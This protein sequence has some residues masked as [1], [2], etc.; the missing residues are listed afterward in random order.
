MSTSSYL[1]QLRPSNSDT[2]GEKHWQEVNG[3][4]LVFCFC[5]YYRVV[6]LPPTEFN[7]PRVCMSCD[8]S[9]SAYLQRVGEVD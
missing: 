2:L 4:S 9:S 3:V 6:A 1:Q 7:V 8:C 5:C